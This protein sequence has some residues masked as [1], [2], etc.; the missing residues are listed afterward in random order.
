ML[1]GPRSWKKIAGFV[2]GRTQVQ[3]RERWLNSL[4]PSLK[5]EE[6]TDGEDSK[7]KAAIAE[8]GY[9]WSKIASH[10]H[11]RTDSQ[12]R[13]RWKVLFP[14]EVPVAQ[15]ARKLQ[16]AALI[17]NF[18]GREKERPAIGPDDFVPVSE[19]NSPDSLV[20]VSEEN[21]LLGASDGHVGTMNKTC[22]TPKLK[23]KRRQKGRASDDLVP[24][25][26]E[27]V[28]LDP[29]DGHVGNMNQTCTTPKLIKKKKGENRASG[30]VAKRG[31]F[32]SRTKK[33]SLEDA[34]ITEGGGSQSNL[35]DSGNASRKA[36][37][38][39]SLNKKKR[40]VED[41]N[42]TTQENFKSHKESKRRKG[43]LS[44][45]DT[46]LNMIH[47]IPPL[48]SF[49]EKKQKDKQ[50]KSV[51]LPVNSPT[52]KKQKKKPVKLGH[53]SIRENRGATKSSMKPISL[54][55]LKQ[56]IREEA[57]TSIV[58]ERSCV[59][60]RAAFQ[61]TDSSK[62][63]GRD[64][65]D[66][67]QGPNAMDENT[68][69]PLQHYGPLLNTRENVSDANPHETAHITEMACCPL[70]GCSS[71]EPITMKE[72]PELSLKEDKMCE[73]C[74]NQRQDADGS[75]V[76]LPQDTLLDKNE[77]SSLLATNLALVSLAEREH[78]SPKKSRRASRKNIDYS[79]MVKGK[80][81][82]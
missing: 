45:E 3:C 32:K 18:V 49:H 68:L 69:V 79:E 67:N 1:F 46:C 10:V 66:Q 23:K 64:N 55:K 75:D 4:D 40:L 5:L 38:R 2:P 39:K 78:A 33:N 29:S 6:W 31:V 70:V 11:P 53:V 26:E 43:A 82:H 56:A 20:P 15:K 12:C 47:E 60:E 25:S 63:R 58:S 80:V 61:V 50:I 9:C 73:Q 81:W 22:T 16:K 7:L 54:R 71:S 44:N 51:S 14:E 41:R 21:M 17:S 30:D 37:S 42:L 48:N 52:K 77:N 76:S 28:L 34:L 62:E 72:S 74:L 57:V 13:R 65:C 27:N 35:C 24:V 36:S 19:E 59:V 8:H